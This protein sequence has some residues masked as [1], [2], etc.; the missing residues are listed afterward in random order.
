MIVYFSGT[1]NSRY[2]AEYLAHTLDDELLDAAGFIRDGISAELISATP[3]VFVCPTY[4]WNIPHIFEQFLRSA[5]LQDNCDAYF[6]LTCG[7]DIGAAG[8][9]LAA[10]CAQLGLSYRGVYPVRMPENYIAMFPVPSREKSRKIVAAA[11]P[12]L[13]NIAGYISR[14]ENFPDQKPSLLDRLKT[15][16]VNPGF[17]RFAVKS[18]RFYAT[19]ACIGCG[20]CADTCPTRAIRLVDGRPVWSDGCTHCMAC[21]CG[22]PCEAIEYGRVSRGKWR[23][24]CPT[25]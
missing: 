8:E 24:Q 9:K 3:W 10:L 2:C 14:G 25:E 5:W 20:K 16:V 13:D 15:N 4:A 21:I 11:R 12:T 6:V 7:D 17:Y 23:Y 18:D 19:D 1:G 22:C